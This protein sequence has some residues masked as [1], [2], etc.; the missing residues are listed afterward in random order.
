MIAAATMFSISS[1]AYDFT[2]IA[3]QM[4]KIAGHLA[5]GECVSQNGVDFCKAEEHWHGDT[6]SMSFQYEGHSYKMT[7]ATW[8]NALAGNF[9]VDIAN[10]GTQQT[11]ISCSAG[12]CEFYTNDGHW[13]ED[14]PT[15]FDYALQLLFP[16][17]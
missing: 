17:E 5:D 2:P 14:R 9:R 6:Y 16:S 3:K 13:T 11:V 12:P 1:D 8:F 10:S 4:A 7:I 15:S